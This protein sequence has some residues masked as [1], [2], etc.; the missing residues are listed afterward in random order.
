MIWNCPSSEVQG[1]T[2]AVAAC[3][4]QVEFENTS[5]GQVVSM[6]KLPTWLI[7]IV[8]EIFTFP[9]SSNSKNTSSPQH[10]IN[11]L[12]NIAHLLTYN[13]HIHKAAFP[14]NTQV[15][16]CILSGMPAGKK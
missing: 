5:F 4:G 16:H 14:D 10:L 11:F 6:V 8:P 1:L 7:E 15:L 9:F 12:I 2:P 3:P 13:I